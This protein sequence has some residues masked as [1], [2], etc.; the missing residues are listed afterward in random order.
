MACK[1]QKITEHSRDLSGSIYGVKHSQAA[2][3]A[4]DNVINSIQFYVDDNV[5]AITCLSNY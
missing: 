4:F 5:I 2:L 3:M 1:H